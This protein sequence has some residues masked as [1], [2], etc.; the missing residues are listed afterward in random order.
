MAKFLGIAIFVACLFYAGTASAG[1]YYI[2]ANGSDANSGTSKTSP[3]LHAPGMPN[4]TGSCAS[5]TPVAGDQFIF[6]GGDTWH[7]GNSAAAPYVGTPVSCVGASEKCSWL[8]QWSGSN[9][10]PIYWGVDQT[11]Y[12]GSSWARPIMNGDN[13]TSTTGVASCPFDE[14]VV[15]LVAVH[16]VS[17]EAIFNTIDNFEFT[18]LCWSGSQQVPPGS[19]SYVNLS[20]YDATVA[21]HGNIIKNIYIHGWTHKAFNC[22]SGPTGDCDGAFGIAGP[23]DTNLGHGDLL[24]HNVIDG[25]DTDGVSLIGTGW[26]C[27]DV[28]Y[29]VYRYVANGMVCNNSHVAHDNLFEFILHSGDGQTHSNATEFNTESHGTVNVFY[30]NIYRHL[31]IGGVGCGNVVVWRTPQ[32]TDYAFNNLIYDAECTSNSNYWDLVTS[33]QGGADGWTDNEFNNTWVLYGA[34]PISNTTMNGTATVNMSNTHCIIPGGGTD[35]NCQTIKGTVSY[36]SNV[37]QDTAVATSQGFSQSEPYAYSPSTVGVATVGT[38]TNK[39]SYCT[40]LLGSSDPLLQA[41]GTACQSDTGYA[42]VYN[43]SSNSI[44]C[45]ARTT[46]PRPSGSVWNAGAYQRSG[47]VVQPASS[48]QGVS[49]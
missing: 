44:T 5:H 23:S 43:A 45:P 10:N 1:T 20:E 47:T 34:V 35:T 38:G 8:L 25:S 26:A 17:G 19:A 16:G 22:A 30:N 4:C 7:F 14:S 46:V 21:N 40:A 33:N 31:F 39:Q 28:E 36:L 41:A 12:S 15:Q 29:S 11:W 48:L 3:W 2:A 6:R 13:P 42:C 49:H 32:T 9:G 27:Y 18:G 24:S 37:I